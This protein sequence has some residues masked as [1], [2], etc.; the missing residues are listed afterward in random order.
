MRTENVVRACFSVY[1]GV[2]VVGANV[3]DDD[4]MMYFSTRQS[5]HYHLTILHE[6][7]ICV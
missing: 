1:C 7:S 5:Q 6:Y 3:D 4:G 2:V